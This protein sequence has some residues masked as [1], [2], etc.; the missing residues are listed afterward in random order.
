MDL[1]SCLIAHIF[2]DITHLQLPETNFYMLGSSF[3]DTTGAFLVANEVICIIPFDLQHCQGYFK[4]DRSASSRVTF[5][6]RWVGLSISHH[7]SYEGTAFVTV[8]LS[9]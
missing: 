8:A 5:S 4:A 6:L 1:L 7:F 3:L 2:S 9:L